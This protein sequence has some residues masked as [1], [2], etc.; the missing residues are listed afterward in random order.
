MTIEDI[1]ANLRV[2]A[3]LTALIGNRIY[4]VRMPQNPTYPLV[5][6]ERISS[7][8]INTMEGYST[9]K[10][11]VSFKCYSDDTIEVRNTAEA[12]LEGLAKILI[13]IED[14]GRDLYDDDVKVFFIPIDISFWR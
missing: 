7:P 11:H 1:L 8:A 12:L 9:H 6:W 10:N 13:E 5:V 2:Y 4:Y 14:A 3:P